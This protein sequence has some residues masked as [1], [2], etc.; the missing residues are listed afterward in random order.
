M[1]LFSRDPIEKEQKI[2]RNE[3]KAEEK[4]LNQALKDLNVAQKQEAK[5]AHAERDAVQDNEKQ[6][7]YIDK[8]ATELAKLQ[9][10][11]EQAI[12]KQQQMAQ[13]V[14]SKH[15]ELLRLQE[16]TVKARGVVEDLQ[17]KYAANNQVRDSRLA[18]L[19]ASRTGS[20]VSPTG[21]SA[22]AGG[23]A[24]GAAATEAAQA[25]AAEA[26]AHAASEDPVPDYATNKASSIAS[27]VSP[28]AERPAL[29]A[30]KEGSAGSVTS[31]VIDEHNGHLH[32]GQAS[33]P[34]PAA[35]PVAVDEHTGHLNIGKPAV[36]APPISP[37][38]AAAEA[39]ASSPIAPP[40]HP[41]AVTQNAA[42]GL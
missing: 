23:A 11:H 34:A 17:A 19:T 3:A 6:K 27:P 30:R 39:S 5:T 36:E 9:T 26:Q 21:A 38:A 8:L 16:E 33:A 35:A 31:P 2:I 40:R 14:E 12:T 20:P 22:A 29:P 15:T 10:Q 7:R 13:E 32:I 18:D 37:T 25:K 41:T 42:A 4:L 28:T 24:A 1:G